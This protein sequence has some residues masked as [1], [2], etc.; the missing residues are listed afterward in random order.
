MGFSA[1]PLLVATKTLVARWFNRR[2]GLAIGLTMSASSLAGIFFP[3]LFAWL[4][5]TIGWQSAKAWSSTGIFFIVMP[6]V[7]FVIKSNPEF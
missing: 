4:I 3:V 1:M 7:Y 5:E 2:L 6:V